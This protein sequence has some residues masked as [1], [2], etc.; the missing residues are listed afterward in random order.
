MLEYLRCYKIIASKQNDSDSCSFCLILNFNF[1]LY[2]EISK[3]N[4]NYNFNFSILAFKLCHKECLF[5]SSSK[6]FFTYSN[7]HLKNLTWTTTK[8]FCA[9]NSKTLFIL[10]KDDI[11][12]KN[13]TFLVLLFKRFKKV[14]NLF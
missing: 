5:Q 2:I 10:T 12:S 14:I 13:F 7:S 1:E 3:K 9:N 4:W 6:Y 8:N 11:Y